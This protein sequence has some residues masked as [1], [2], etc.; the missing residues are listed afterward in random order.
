M[1]G[2]VARPRCHDVA[3][4]QALI[5][6]VGGQPVASSGLTVVR[7]ADAQVSP[8]RSARVVPAAQVARAWRLAHLAAGARDELQRVAHLQEAGDRARG[9]SRAAGAEGARWRD[10]ARELDAARDRRAFDAS[11]FVGI[12]VVHGDARSALG[13]DE[14]RPIVVIGDHPDLAA[15]LPEGLRHHPQV[16]HLPEA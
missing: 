12:A 14:R 1:R 8:P 10:R 9:R 13:V 5:R 15:W 2:A 4:T 11:V 16:V 3:M 6:T 7:G